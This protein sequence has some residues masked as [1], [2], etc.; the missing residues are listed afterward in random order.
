MTLAEPVEFHKSEFAKSKAR[1]IIEQYAEGH[2]F[3]DISEG[4]RRAARKRDESDGAR[5]LVKMFEDRVGRDA[6]FK[7]QLDAY[8]AAVR[9]NPDWRKTD[10][11]GKILVTGILGT[12]PDAKRDRIM[13]SFLSGLA[14]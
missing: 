14:P 11:I 1:R 2:S 7:S 12:D 6:E 5:M 13:K 8:K 10:G 3:E 9:E 4:F